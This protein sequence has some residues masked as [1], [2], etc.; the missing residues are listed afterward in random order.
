[1][2][3]R[4]SLWEILRNPKYTGYQVWNRRARKKGGRPNHPSTWVWSE[5]PAHPAIVSREELEAVAARASAN[6]RSRKGVAPNTFPK[7]TE[8]LYR[9]LLRCGACGLRMWGNTRRAT[10]YY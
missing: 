6:H 8:Y 2:W 7:R 10:R 4:S 1:M 3:S 9:G 5:E